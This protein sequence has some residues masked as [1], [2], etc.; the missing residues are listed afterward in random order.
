MRPLLFALPLILLI[1]GVVIYDMGHPPPPLLR[2][3]D[4]VPDLSLTAYDGS[5]FRLSDHDG[6]VIVLSFFATW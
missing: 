3:G 4:Q 6:D 5:T 2:S 1:A